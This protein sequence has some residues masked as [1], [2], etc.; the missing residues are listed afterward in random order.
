MKVSRELAS[1]RI[2]EYVTTVL[3]SKL[4]DKK[5]DNAARFKIGWAHTMGMLCITD[6]QFADAKELGLVDAEGN[7][8]AGGDLNV[9]GETQLGEPLG[10]DYGGT[11][12]TD[13]AGDDFAVRAE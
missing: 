13:A 2:D 6:E 12:A 9:A 4:K 5:A 3:L 1:K 11:G 7:I 10:V 8:D